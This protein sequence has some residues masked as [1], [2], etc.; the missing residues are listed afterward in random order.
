MQAQLVAVPLGNQCMDRSNC[1]VSQGNKTNWVTGKLDVSTILDLSQ[2]LL[3]HWD[4]N[5]PASVF[6]PY[7]VFQGVNKNPSANQKI[8]KKEFQWLPLIQKL[9]DHLRPYFHT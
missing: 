1:S 8:E 9:V 2:D 3:N 6:N 5:Y 7:K 4:K